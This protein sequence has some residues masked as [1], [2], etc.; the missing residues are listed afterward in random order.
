[1]ERIEI[2]RELVVSTC[3]F[4]AA[5]KM[6]LR[7]G[8]VEK[9]KEVIEQAYSQLNAFLSDLADKEDRV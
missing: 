3:L 4:L 7:N 9:A 2:E 8:E 1:M 6:F 5:A